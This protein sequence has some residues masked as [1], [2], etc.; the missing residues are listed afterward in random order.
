MDEVYAPRNDVACRATIT[1][2][3]IAPTSI[4]SR[5][6][7]DRTTLKFFANPHRRRQPRDA[8]SLLPSGSGAVVAEL[9]AATF[10][11]QATP[12]VSLSALAGHLGVA[13][14]QVKDEGHRLGLRSFKALGGAYAVLQLVRE[15]ASRQLQRPIGLGELPRPASGSLALPPSGALDGPGAADVRQV[16]SG[17]VFACA[18]DGNHGQSVA[19]GA[20]LVGAQAV[21]FVHEGVSAARVAAIARFGARI[22][23]V[24]GTYDDAVAESMR[25]CERQGWTLLS[26]TSW[27][28]YEDVPARVMQGYT[29]IAHEVTTQTRAAPSHV[30]LQAG[31]GGFAAALAS[32][33]SAAYESAPPGIVVVEPAR[34]ACLLASAEAGRALKIDAGPSTLMSML[35]CYEPSLV[36]WNILK[37]LAAAFMT[38]DEADAVQAMKLLAYPTGP[39][40]AIVAGE[41]GG[42]GLAG[43]L[44]AC[45][46][47]SA[48]AAIGLDASSHVLLVNTESATDAA[49]YAREVGASP[50][51]VLAGIER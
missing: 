47:S 17:L 1:S 11:Y 29:L 26:D 30:F 15:A 21:V 4:G 28:G 23:V 50:E 20:R 38:V 27:P 2:T 3:L 35:E 41:S 13:S 40:R 49:S 45:R 16:A 8:E 51:Q 36:A 43:L 37:P 14:V 31:V 33:L 18:T 22:E 24:R 48:R 39:D 42:A 10:D 44:V 46:D 9:L 12:L 5:V 7:H 34:A 32:A 19:A 25:Q 6:R